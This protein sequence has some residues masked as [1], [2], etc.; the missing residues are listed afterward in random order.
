MTRHLLGDA[1]Q[2]WWKP[3][4]T[5]VEALG[6]PSDRRSSKKVMAG[7]PGSPQ[8]YSVC[9]SVETAEKH[10]ATGVH[11]PEASTASVVSNSSGSR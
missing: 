7:T 3:A 4:V 5:R 1:C 10:G 6:H 8:G 11:A 9:L 2:F